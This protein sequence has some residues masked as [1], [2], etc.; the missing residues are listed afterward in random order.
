VRPAS[1]SASFVQV[2]GVSC[3]AADDCLLVG[4]TTSKHGAGAALAERWNGH[5]WLR[6]AVVGELAGGGSLAGVDCGPESSPPAC[7]VVGQTVGKGSG[8]IPIHPLV[9]RWNGLSFSIVPSPSGGRGNYPELK[10]VACSGQGACQAVG[11]RG[12]GEDDAM[13]LT[14][15][16]NAITWSDESSPSPLYG[17]RT[18]SGVACPSARDCWAVGE[19]LVRSGEGT[20]MIIEHF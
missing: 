3:M 12:A 19:G 4:F 2:N 10:A 1:V 7:W 17:F 20:R 6:L 9:A 16:W 15:G 18:L 8:L 13:V 14:E 11:S 5:F